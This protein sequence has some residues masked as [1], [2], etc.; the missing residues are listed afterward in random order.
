MLAICLAPTPASATAPPPGAT[1]GLAWE[2]RSLI[3][4]QTSTATLAKGGNP[5]HLADWTKYGGVARLRLNFGSGAYSCTGTLL[6][7]RVSILTAAHCA[8]M[9]GKVAT[10]ASVHFRGPGEADPNLAVSSHV[11]QVSQFFVHPDYTGAVVDQADIAVLRLAAPAPDHVASHALSSVTALGGK[12]FTILGQGQRSSAGGAI[13]VTSDAPAGFMRQGENRFDYRLGDPAFNG[14]FTSADM[15]G[16]IAENSW[17][18]DFDNGTSANDGA[19]RLAGTMGLSGTKYCNRG[20]GALEVG[21]AGGD[22]GGPQFIKGSIAAVTSFG[23]SFGTSLG[24]YRGGFNSSWGEIIGFVPVYLHRPWLDSVVLASA[25]LE[26]TG[27]ERALVASAAPEP[28]TWAML[29]AGL[30]I[31]GAAARRRPPA[32]A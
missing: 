22:S 14:I 29:V 20:R 30:G 16:A 10:S 9:D 19:C 8:Q 21:A 13:G 17:I 2:A 1:A 32:L 18:A 15:Y 25:M 6:P 3:V 31:V 7:D 4:G 24:D 23:I 5:A 26:G 28:G 27:V 11:V 12:T